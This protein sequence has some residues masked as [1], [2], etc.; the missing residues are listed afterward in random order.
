MIPLISF[1][2]KFDSNNKVIMVHF[3]CGKKFLVSQKFN[4]NQFTLALLKQISIIQFSF[5]I[6]L[7]ILEEWIGELLKASKCRFQLLKLDLERRSQILV[8]EFKSGNIN[9]CSVL[10]GTFSRSSR[11]DMFCKKGV[12]RNL[13]KFKGKHLCQSLFLNKVAG[14]RPATLL[15]RD[16]GTGVFL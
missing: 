10:T 15:K 11:P 13:T 8:F 14:L 7:H 4:N 12:L 2:Y 9:F 16:S 1:V 5:D 6:L 3:L